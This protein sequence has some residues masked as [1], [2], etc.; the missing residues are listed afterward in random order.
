MI[1][2]SKGTYLTWKSLTEIARKLHL[3]EDD[4]RAI[5]DSQKESGQKLI[6]DRND[7]VQNLLELSVKRLTTILT[8]NKFSL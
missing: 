6:I 7:T 4:G 2:G 3:K 8:E 1:S 5:K